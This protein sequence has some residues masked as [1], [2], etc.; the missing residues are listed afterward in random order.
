MGTFREWKDNNPSLVDHIQIQYPIGT[1]TNFQVRL[2]YKKRQGVHQREIS[3]LDE[4][5]KKC[6]LIIKKM[7]KNINENDAKILKFKVKDLI[8]DRQIDNLAIL[9]LAFLKRKIIVLKNKMSKLI[10]DIKT[11]LKDIALLMQ[12][13]CS[14]IIPSNCILSISNRFFIDFNIDKKGK[15]KLD[16][17]VQ[18]KS[19]MKERISKLEKPMWID[20]FEDFFKNILEKGTQQID[21]NFF[22]FPPLKEETSFSRYLFGTKSKIGMSI[23]QF[24]CNLHLSNFEGFQTKSIEF[25]SSLLPKNLIKNSIDQSAGLLVLFRALMDRLYE[26]FPN[27]FSSQSQ[28]YKIVWRASKLPLSFF[29]VSNKM[30]CNIDKNKPIKDIFLEDSYFAETVDFINQIAFYI[31]PIDILSTLNKAQNLIHVGAIGNINGRKPNK[32]DLK[33]VL[34]FDD[35]F[36]LLLGVVISSDIPD[37][38]QVQESLQMFTPNGSL[39]IF[40]EYALAN[41]EAI[42]LY[43]RNHRNDI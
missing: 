12:L 29:N 9:K 27:Y 22:Y 38:F 24:I 41:F 8:Y 20:H 35:L 42:V 14:E 5:R 4:Y 39:S 6:Q 7:N 15:T 16:K 36:S 28:E 43:F 10:N 40:L 1:L 11:K 26:T 17:L 31:C 2:F 18:A 33:T 25:C 13:F 3:T 23:D 37:I 21:H 32:E 34:A 30:F 19:Q